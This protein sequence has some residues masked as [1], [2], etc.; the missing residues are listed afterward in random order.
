MTDENQQNEVV[1]E[2]KPNKVMN[3]A[4]IAFMFLFVGLFSIFVITEANSKE[5]VKF[6]KPDP[7]QD[8]SKGIELVEKFKC[9]TCHHK[10]QLIFGP[11]FQDIAQ[12]YEGDMDKINYLAGKIHGG[13][14]G[15]WSK[16]KIMTSHKHIPP[17][18]LQMMVGWILSLYDESKIV[19][20]PPANPEN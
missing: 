3:I 11:S 17:D 1:V 14:G 12:Y 9:A 20:F 16:F 13:A 6:E 5:E 2:Q 7:N 8:F 4:I 15:K 19:E 10:D 18:E